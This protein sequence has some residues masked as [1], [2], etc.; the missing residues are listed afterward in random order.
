MVQTE[1]VEN[2][3]RRE[4]NMTIGEKLKSLRVRMGMTLKEQSEILGV[5]L[6]TVYRWESNMTIPRRG[7][8][9]AIAKHYGVSTEWLLNEKTLAEEIDH[10][11]RRLLDMFKQLSWENRYK[12]WIYLEFLL[13]EMEEK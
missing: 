11:Q 4:N 6:N 7:T 10:M 9:I 5:S 12:I 13:F 8:L 2:L 1:S 3:K